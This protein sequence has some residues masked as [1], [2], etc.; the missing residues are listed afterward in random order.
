MQYILKECRGNKMIK[1][2]KR[3]AV[4]EFM[5]IYGEGLF[6]KDGT[7][8]NRRM[9]KVANREQWNNWTDQLCKEGRITAHQFNTWQYP[10][11]KY[12]Y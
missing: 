9:D 12:F 8:G 3:E 11:N 4:K 7:G 5:Y 10:R 1:L 6:K 2:T